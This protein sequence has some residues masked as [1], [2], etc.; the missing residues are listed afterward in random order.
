MWYVDA[1]KSPTWIVRSLSSDFIH[2]ETILALQHGEQGLRV[3]QGRKA[4]QGAQRTGPMDVVNNGCSERGLGLSRLQTRTNPIKT[5]QAP[6][7]GCPSIAPK[8][9]Q[10]VSTQKNK[11][12]ERKTEIKDR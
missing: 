3:S 2:P 7:S 1:Y 8:R 12:K 10:G 11:N 6:D 9:G 5:T 4:A